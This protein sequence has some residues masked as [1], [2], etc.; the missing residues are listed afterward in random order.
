MPSLM[1]GNDEDIWNPVFTD[2]TLLGAK[3]YDP[4]TWSV[5]FVSDEFKQ[6]WTYWIIKRGAWSFGFKYIR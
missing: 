5:P 4:R 6:G 2:A 3:Y 1:C